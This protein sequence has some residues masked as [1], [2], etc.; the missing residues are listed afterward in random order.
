MTS[1]VDYLV[2]RDD[3][4]DPSGL[5][6]D[7][8]LGGDGLY[9]ATRNQYLE[10]RIPVARAAVRGLP[11]LY[12]SFSLRNGRLPQALWGVIVAASCAWARAERE[13]L[14]SVVHDEILG[15]QVVQPRQATGPTA[16]R[17]RPIEDGVLEI[18]SHHRFA[19]RFSPTDD[20]DEQALRI[21]GVL[22]RLGS[23]R[24][25]LAL[26]AGAYGYF[27]PVPWEA[28]FDGERGGFSDGHFDPPTE[29]DRAGEGVEQTDGDDDLPD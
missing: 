27:L 12:P 29:P 26:R 23:D 28:V 21:Y 10:V 20:A 22:G 18:H 24:P 25:E 1:L 2:V 17:Y 19:A 8:M 6:Y 4:P 7:Y 9:V 16:V 5:A 11:P 14:F 15:Y 3:P 13:V